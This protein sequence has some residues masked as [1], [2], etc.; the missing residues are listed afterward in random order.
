M[1]KPRYRWWGYV[2]A[3]VRAYPVL[4]DKYNHL[5]NQSLCAA[6]SGMPHGSDV[7]R[8]TETIAT[9]ELPPAEQREYDAV[10][11]AIGTTER[12]KNGRDRLK[13]IELVY[14]K[15]SHTLA[16]AALYIPA[17]YDAAQNWQGEFIRLVASYLGVMD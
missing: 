5:H 11:R 14:W 8:T 2:K 1:S 3:V 6:L 15:Q 10:R 12:Y 16:G 7:A 13:I 4:R 17:S 9:T